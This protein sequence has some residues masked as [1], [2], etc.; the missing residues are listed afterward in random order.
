MWPGI[1]TYRIGE[2]SARRITSQDIV[3]EIDTTRVRAPKEKSI[4]HI[5]F[6]MT[7]LMKNPDSLN[8]KLAVRYS[9]AAL[10]P[11][12]PWLGAK[13]PGKPTVKLASSAATGEPVITMTP[14]KGQ[15]PWL[16]TV[17]TR[18]N[19]SWTSE[20]LP[21]WMRTHRLAPSSV[22][23]VVVTAVSRTGIESAEAKA[24]NQP[25]R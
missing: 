23:E 14:V 13:A 17:R 20:V 15:T 19:G 21:G 10:V 8:E 6:S 1:A 16:W 12:S 24:R 22:D 25:A 3:D 9:E 18:S 4:G 11:A 5:H 7:A 2:N